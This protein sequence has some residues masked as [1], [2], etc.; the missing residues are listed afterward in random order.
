[1]PNTIAAPS[2][3]KTPMIPVP[4][5]PTRTTKALAEH[6]ST[7]IP[8]VRV[9]LAAAGF[10]DLDTNK[11]SQALIDEGLAVVTEIDSNYVPGTK[12]IISKFA[13]VVGER[14]GLKMP[15]EAVRLSHVTSIR[16]ATSQLY[17][18]IEDLGLGVGVLSK[19][20][21]HVNSSGQFLALHGISKEQYDRLV[22]TR[23][24]DPHFL[25]G[26]PAW[27]QY[28]ESSSDVMRLTSQIRDEFK[29]LFDKASSNP[30]LTPSVEAVEL[31]LAWIEKWA[32]KNFSP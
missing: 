11:A 26:G 32:F 7:T 4:F 18:L 14:A 16:G 15:S 21:R 10:L 1:M 13:I 23:F 27:L 17:S 25:P 3:T 20:D 28:A 30:A 29:W 19:D 2:K 22:E 12:A 5:R 8:K 6:F 24:C 9:A 31:V